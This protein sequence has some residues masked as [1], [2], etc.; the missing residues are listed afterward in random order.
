MPGS[1]VRE[2]A[3]L[4][5]KYK[6]GAVL[7]VDAGKLIGIFTER[8]AV[9]RV[10]ASNRD[11]RQTY[12]SE[13]MTR[14]PKTVAPDET[15]G[16]A[17][18]LMHENGFRHAPVVGCDAARQVDGHDER[19][20]RR[21]ARTRDPL[22]AEPRADARHDLACATPQRGARRGAD[23]EDPVDEHVGR[24]DRGVEPRGVGVGVEVGRPRSVRGR[25]AR[26]VHPRPDGDDPHVGAALGEVRSGEQRVAAVV[27]R[28]GEHD[29]ERAWRAIHRPTPVFTSGAA[30]DL[31]GE[32]ER[33]A[34]HER[35]PRG[36]QRRLGGAHL[37]GRVALAGRRRGGS[38]CVGA[39]APTL[40]RAIR[41][42][43]S[44]R[45][46]FSTD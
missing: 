33:G 5:R 38:R 20:A 10:I 29:D 3:S 25:R 36:E 28:P 7:V 39:H 15:F 2:A 30:R 23:A 17:L 11:P 13:A 27:A 6:V 8:D 44:H 31:V 22:G 26:L 45:I 37:L 21:A 40:R 35:L 32:R 46:T 12:V 19:M 34:L 1:T 9:Y 4:M 43:Q 24:V 41:H 16:H 14:N 18:L 42:S